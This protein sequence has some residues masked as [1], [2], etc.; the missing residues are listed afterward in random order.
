MIDL[1][2]NIY[3]QSCTRDRPKFKVWTSAGLLLTYRCN[4]SCRFCYYHC[5][6]DKRG[7]MPVDMAIGIWQSLKVLAGPAAKVHLTGGEPFLDW[8]HL[9]EVLKV[10]HQGRLGP[11][12][13]IETNG[14]WATEEDLVRER[15]RCLDELGVERLKISCDP[16]HQEFI[17]IEQ[18]RRLTSIAREILGPAKVQVRWEQYL[19]LDSMDGSMEAF[20]RSMKE[21]PCRFTGRAAGDLAQAMAS[22]TPEDLRSLDCSQSFLGAKGIHVDPLGNVF[23]GTCSGIIIGNVAQRPLDQ[24][25]RSFDPRQNPAVRTLVES[26]PCGLLDRA[27]PHGYVPLPA[28]ADRCHLCTH[29][30]EFLF[31]R[32]LESALI[33]PAECYR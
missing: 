20:L 1:S 2:E 11:V 25:W 13:A 19:N 15:V 16:F 30:R 22:R 6:P 33:G 18:V 7:Q 3:N 4:A 28:Y 5:S 32:A 24:I 8:D 14:F 9:V 23:S 26:G 10:C 31:D 29:V 21:R 27:L 12:D 17:P